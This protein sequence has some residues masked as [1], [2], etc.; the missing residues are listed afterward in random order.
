MK[1]NPT[2]E[3]TKERD[4]FTIR[5]LTTFKNNEIK[6]KLGVTFHEVTIDGRHCQVS[7]EVIPHSKIPNQIESFLHYQRLFLFPEWNIQSKLK[8]EVCFKTH[9]KQLIPVSVDRCN[10]E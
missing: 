6:F 2:I 1:L 9:F 8:F 5:T 4:E 10:G 7:L 3:I